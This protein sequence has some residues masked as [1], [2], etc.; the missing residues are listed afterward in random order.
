[1]G[2]RQVQVRMYCFGCFCVV[3]STNV[4]HWLGRVHMMA[5]SADCDRGW[6][7]NERERRKE[8]KEQRQ[9]YICFDSDSDPYRLTH[10]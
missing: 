10:I 2:P 6:R 7:R 1:M 4:A 5:G 3:M 9:R 8:E